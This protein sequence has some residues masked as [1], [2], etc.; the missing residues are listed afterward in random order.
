M[1]RQHLH[2]HLG[3]SLLKVI[4]SP[5]R[6]VT[7][8]QIQGQICGRSALKGNGVKNAV[9]FCG[10]RTCVVPCLGRW[11]KI[12]G[13]S[14]L[15][16]ESSLA[17]AVAWDGVIISQFSARAC[18]HSGSKLWRQ[19]RP[20][21][22]LICREIYLPAQHAEISLCGWIEEGRRPKAARNLCNILFGFGANVTPHFAQYPICSAVSAP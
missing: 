15:C 8:S 18:G 2:S 17:R 16:A 13:A 22:S 4:H 20:S 12:D 5:H 10:R 7:N 14:P 3:D 6:G 9:H 21:H 11:I 19:K 1:Q